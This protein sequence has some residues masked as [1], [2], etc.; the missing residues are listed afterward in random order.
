M[1]NHVLSKRAQSKE[2][3]HRASSRKSLPGSTL[4][5]VEGGVWTSWGLTK[6]I[7]DFR[8]KEREK[9]PKTGRWGVEVVQTRPVPPAQLAGAQGR[10]NALQVRS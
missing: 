8:A 1:S 10:Q 7:R 6:P 2:R 4:I 5:A 3:T 9:G